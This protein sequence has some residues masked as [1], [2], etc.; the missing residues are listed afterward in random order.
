MSDDLFRALHFLAYL[1]VYLATFIG[2]GLVLQ[3]RK[4]HPVAC[5]SAVGAGLV[6]M[7]NWGVIWMSY[8]GTTRVMELCKLY[9]IQSAYAWSAFDVVL[10]LL[11]TISVVLLVAALL[12][13]R[14]KEP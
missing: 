11:Q 7:V 12:V 14:R 5:W 4:T 3:L 8:W 13:G 2:V 1:P 9:G 10:S 6:L